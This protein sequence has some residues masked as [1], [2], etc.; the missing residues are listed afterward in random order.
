MSLLLPS[1]K[2]QSPDGSLEVMFTSFQEEINLQDNL[3]FTFNHDVLD[4][5]SLIGQ[6]MDGSFLKIEPEVPGKYQWI[7]ADQLVFS[8][9]TGFSPAT[10]YTILV[11]DEILNFTTTYKDLTGD[12]KFTVHSPY[13]SLLTGHAA[14]SKND[15]GKTMAKITSVLSFAVDAELLKDLSVISGDKKLA[16]ETISEGISNTH[17][18]QLL[19]DPDPASRERLKLELPAI[20]G[21]SNEISV[22][23]L[24]LEPR[25]E[26]KISKVEAIT[27]GTTAMIRVYTSQEVNEKAIRKNLSIP[28]MDDYNIAPAWY[29]FDITSDEIKVG[30]NYTVNIS[31]G[32]QGSLGGLLSRNFSQTVTFAKLAPDISFNESSA[33]YLTT[34][35]HRNISVNI[36][37]VPNIKVSIYKVFENN[38]VHFLDRDKRWG[39]YWNYDEDL[40]HTD[41]YDYRYYEISD[42][43]QLVYEQEMKTAGMDRSGIGHLLHLDFA[44]ELKD[45]PGVYIIQVEDTEHYYISDSRIVSLSDIGMRG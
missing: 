33:V 17:S 6:W 38:L 11:R 45:K 8:P 3:R 40:G 10:E 19:D 2:E 39:S 22:L 20:N 28:Y 14:W 25:D 4:N 31:K 36:V 35:G 9:A 43:G 5:D 23:T 15:E 37:S 44:D 26:L 24:F 32:L 21:L 1:C 7:R 34:E 12:K 16:V 30:G 29:G 27:E 42:V 41:Y 13:L 18:F